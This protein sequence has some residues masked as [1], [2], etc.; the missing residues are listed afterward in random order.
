MHHLLN[1]NSL[2]FNPPPIQHQPKSYH[3]GTMIANPHHRHHHHQQFVP[4]SSIQQYNNYHY[5][6]PYSQE[7]ST[8]YH[9]DRLRHFSHSHPTYSSYDANNNY[10]DYQQYNLLR[11]VLD[12]EH[13]PS[14]YSSS[15]SSMG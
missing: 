4:S 11:P 2:P 1:P 5:I 3:T 6:N 9:S 15:S 13:Y 8:G 14:Y 12:S 7:N 10:P